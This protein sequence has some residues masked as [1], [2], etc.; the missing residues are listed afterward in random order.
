MMMT[1]VATKVPATQV[2]AVEPL[3]FK[4][5][6]FSTTRVRCSYLARMAGSFVDPNEGEQAGSSRPNDQTIVE[7]YQFVS[8]G[9]FTSSVLK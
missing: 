5:D 1:A 7:V 4:G 8:V 9:I 3:S 6:W 2:C